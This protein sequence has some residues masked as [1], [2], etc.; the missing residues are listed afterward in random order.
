MNTPKIAVPGCIGTFVT[1]VLEEEGCQILKV[2]VEP[3][4]EI[5]LHSHACSA[6]MVIMRGKSR[7]LG[8]GERMVKKG[9]VV[10]KAPHEPHGF[11][12]VTEPFSFLSIS[13]NKGIMQRDGWDMKYA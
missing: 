10:V 4:G 9:D 6:T 2:D 7:A 3:G 13:D 5:P 11:T 1:E 12:E 8:K